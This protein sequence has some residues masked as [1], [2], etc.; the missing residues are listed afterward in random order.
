MRSERRIAGVA[1]RDRIGT[2]LVGDAPKVLLLGSGE[3]G[4]EIAI[5]A[6][7]LGAEVIA[8]DRYAN[9]PAMHVAHRHRVVPMTDPAALRALVRREDPD[10]IV[11]E[12]E[13]I[14]T[15]ELVRLEAE[16]WTVIPGA[17]STRTTMDRER[18]RRLA[19]E[20]AHV[21][22]SRFAFVESAS[23][24]RIAAR[25]LG[26][27]CVFK[28]MMSSSG[29]GMTVVRDLGAVDAAY[30][31]ASEHGRVAN[32]RVMLEEF[33]PFD[34]E[35]TMLTLR[36]F[37]P[38]GRVVTT[39]FDPVGHARPSTLY[40]ESWQPQAFPPDVRRSLEA[41]ASAVT[42][43]LGGVGMFGVECFVQGGTTYFSEVSPRPHDTG[44]VTLASQWNSEFA[45]HARAI[46]G[47]PYTGPE[48]TV[49][50]AAHVILGSTAGWA[51]SFGGLSKAL[52]SSGVRV[53]LFGKPESYPDR[54]LGVAVAR[55]RTVEEA[56]TFA[57]T[58]A[59]AVEEAI[60][61]RSPATS[62]A[63]SS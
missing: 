6:M 40:H 60:E 48:P 41:T 50:A 34:H 18:L 36:H 20:K 52:A 27:P 58:A 14:A 16:G 47:L 22:T 57:E 28:S 38:E 21:R 3:L 17:E 44:L 25:D 31:E 23:A 49:P 51:P 37:N 9:A 1:F 24:A 19:S 56:R 45:L 7:R 5:E 63:T 53:F 39:V 2:P 35:V 13:Q 30:R 33:L 46:L 11:P 62:S 61:T 10:V 4:R 12:I 43:E 15:D 55:G 8:A 42:D 59:H 29:H 32:P 54:R 26:L